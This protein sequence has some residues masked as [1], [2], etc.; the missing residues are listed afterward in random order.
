M[1]SLKYILDYFR[2]LKLCKNH[3]NGKHY[4]FTK[5]LEVVIEKITQIS[6]Q[7][8]IDYMKT[9]LFDIVQAS[10]IYLISNII[11]NG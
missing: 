3:K 1:T 11:C 7:K 9:R 4:E 8:L 5:E 6:L 10:E 2:Y